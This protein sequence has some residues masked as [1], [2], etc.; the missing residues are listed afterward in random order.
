MITQ[1]IIDFFIN[2]LVYIID[3]LPNAL[4][5]TAIPSNIFSAL[6]YLGDL[7]AY[8]LPITDIALIFGFT[9][10]FTNW[11]LIYSVVM[12]IWDALPLT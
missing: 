3:L 7:S 9:L 10:A 6:D 5:R 11:R 8:F 12:R 2:I 1:A 4:S